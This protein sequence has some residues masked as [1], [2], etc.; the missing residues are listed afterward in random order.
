MDSFLESNGVIGLIANWNRERTVLG[1]GHGSHLY[2]VMPQLAWRLSEFRVSKLAAVWSISSSSMLV[3]CNPYLNALKA[4]MG[5]AVRM[6]S[7]SGV[8]MALSLHWIPARSNASNSRPCRAYGSITN[9]N[10]FEIGYTTSSSLVDTIFRERMDTKV[11]QQYWWH[12]RTAWLWLRG[13]PAVVSHWWSGRSVRTLDHFR[14]SSSAPHHHSHT[15]PGRYQGECVL[16]RDLEKTKCILRTIRGSKGYERDDVQ[17]NQTKGL[18]NRRA[19]P[20]DP[21]WEWWVSTGSGLRSTINGERCRWHC[22]EYES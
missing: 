19:I 10:S 8:R 14:R 22:I 9:L 17:T 4:S 20:P 18:L 2:E 15:R 11:A 5:N 6:S 7:C 12:I 3:V 13:T 21:A 16:N 1:D